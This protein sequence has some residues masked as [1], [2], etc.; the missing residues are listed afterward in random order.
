M[1]CAKGRK[2]DEDL[3]NDERCELDCEA[4]PD[5]EGCRR[6]CPKDFGRE[7]GS[8]SRKCKK[9]EQGLRSPAG[10]GYCRNPRTG[11][12]DADHVLALASSRFGFYLVCD[13]PDAETLF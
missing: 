12:F 11:C 1:K 2:K 7:R 4:V 3:H 5:Q 10:E 9:C 6:G 8:E 13:S